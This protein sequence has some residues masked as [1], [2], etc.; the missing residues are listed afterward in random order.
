MMD[1][2]LP[3]GEG[4][5]E[6]TTPPAGYWASSNST[7]GSATRVRK[8]RKSW[9]ITAT[10]VSELVKPAAFH[11]STCVILATVKAK[12]WHRAIAPINLQMP[13]CNS[14]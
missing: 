11:W 14:R 6:E 9:S 5:L 1:Y 3:T 8:S 10:P 12:Q 7:V 4:E 13:Q 2:T